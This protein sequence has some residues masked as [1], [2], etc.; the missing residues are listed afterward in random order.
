MSRHLAPLLLAALTAAC[1]SAPRPPEQPV[2]VLE[3]EPGR[4]HEVIAQVTARGIPGAS[5]ALV[6]DK[7]R[8]KARSLGADAVIAVETRQH[9]DATPAPYDPP[10]RPLLGNAYPGP[11]HSF[12]PG[13]FPPE[14]F[15][16]RSRGPYYVAEGL[17]IRY[18]PEGR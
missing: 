11:L 10:Q 2:A 3:E 6:H 1:A 18:L 17:A 12:D 16:V 5:I 14:G 8:D 7:L 13:S 4:P 9:F 15:N